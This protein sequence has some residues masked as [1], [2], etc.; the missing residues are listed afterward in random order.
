MGNFLEI[1]K[2]RQAPGILVFDFNNQLLYS[3]QEVLTLI[4][5]ILASGEQEKGRKAAIFAEIFDLCENL[6]QSLIPGNQVEPQKVAKTCTFIADGRQQLVS[7]R[8]FMID[9]HNGAGGKGHIMVMGERVVENHEPNFA[10]IKQDFTL[11]SREMEVLKQVFA[12]LA[13]RAIAEKLFI[14]EHTVK[15]HLKN[16][17][18]KMGASSRNEIMATLKA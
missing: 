5:D 11:S 18:K 16:I 7:L 1:I 15:D 17:M 14:S 4:P 13:N 6:K 3:N 10:K 9:G 12:G 2:G 8:A